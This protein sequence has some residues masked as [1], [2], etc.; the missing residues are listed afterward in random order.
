MELGTWGSLR[1]LRSLLHR[2]YAIVIQA[3]RLGSDS[4]SRPPLPPLLGSTGS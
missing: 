4:G 2:L 1:P 3:P